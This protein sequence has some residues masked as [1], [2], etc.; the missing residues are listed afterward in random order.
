MRSPAIIASLAAMVGLTSVLAG[1]AYTKPPEFRQYDQKEQ[2]DRDLFG[3][4]T[5][6]S[7]VTLLSTEKPRPQSDEGTGSGGG[8]GIG[9]NA[10]LWRGTLETI[11][12]M[13]LAS[14][15]P[16][17]G[18]IIT[19]WYQPPE[20]PGERLKVQ[21][22]IRDQSL[23]ADGLKVSVFRQVKE[24]EG[25]VDATV[26]PTTA[27]RLEDSILTRAREL[28]VASVEAAG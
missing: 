2:R 4:V 12:F 3:T 5:G 8:G 9:V 18:L 10:Y 11:N 22:L 13:P 27:T 25:W 19:D 21:I 17:G 15:D 24:G 7:G 28:R 14:A 26:D 16:F 1:C 23:R 6:T 20:S